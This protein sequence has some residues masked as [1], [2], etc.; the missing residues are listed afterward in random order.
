MESASWRLHLSA[1]TRE[2]MT[3]FRFCFFLLGSGWVAEGD[4]LLDAFAQF[5]HVYFARF[6]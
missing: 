4:D 6:V 1:F 2:T 5:I 3:G